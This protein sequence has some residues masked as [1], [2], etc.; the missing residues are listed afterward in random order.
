VRCAQGGLVTNEKAALRAMGEDD[1][2]ITA[3][4]LAAVIGANE[5]T[6]YRILERFLTQ[7]LV[8]RRWH[9][10]EDDSRPV[11]VHQLT[12]AGWAKAAELMGGGS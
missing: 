7:G 11:R 2:W 4:E 1:L 9:C 3:A 5:A 8:V 12:A 6:G 10:P